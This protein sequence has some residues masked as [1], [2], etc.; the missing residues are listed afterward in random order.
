MLPGPWS[1]RRG[2][3]RPGHRP[4]GG[5]CPPAGNLRRP[6]LGGG[7]AGAALGP[8]ARPPHP[9]RHQPWPLCGRALQLATHEATARDEEVGPEPPGE[10]CAG[11]S[12]LVFSTGSHTSPRGRSG[13]GCAVPVPPVCCS[14]RWWTSAAGPAGTVQHR[15]ARRALQGDL[16]VVESVGGTEEGGQLGCGCGQGAVAGGS[17]AITSVI[18]PCGG[19]GPV[20]DHEP[21]PRPAIQPLQDSWC[22]RGTQDIGRSP[23]VGI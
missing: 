9:P 13:G 14:C 23:S 12:A 20:A 6:R 19:P 8:P 15:P 5:P 18:I 10:G 11:S 1:R 21:V 17:W 4:A 16:D 2:V 3:G 22:R 7:P